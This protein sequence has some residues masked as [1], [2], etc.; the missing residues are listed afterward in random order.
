MLSEVRAA[1][2]LTDKIGRQITYLRMSVTEDCNFRCGYCEGSSPYS[3]ERKSILSDY[4]VIC[5]VRAA[6]K[7]GIKKVRFT[8]GEPLLRGNL[9]GIIKEIS[10]RSPELCIGIT[11]NGFLLDSRLQ[12]LIDAGLNRLNISLDSLDRITFKSLTGID[13]LE[14]VL[15]AIES[16]LA[17]G[18]FDSIKINTVVLR[19]IND[20]EIRSLAE[21]ALPRDIDIRFIEYMPLAGP[22]HVN[23]LYVP[24]SEMREKIGFE[25]VEESRADNSGPARL[26][27]CG[28]YPGRIGFISAVSRCFCGECNRLRITSRGDV[29]GCLFG[30]GDRGLRR[31]LSDGGGEQQIAEYLLT[32][33]EHPGFRRTPGISSIGTRHDRMR[34]IGG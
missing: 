31:L 33:L 5:I 30:E 7:A 22:T 23:D 12:G 6:V 14:R 27:K 10:F 17:S 16:A 1:A 34:S 18:R 29:Y 13:G 11:T 32:L 28:N 20:H 4:E 19:G 25:L 21:W 8:G 2:R 15:S 26:F 3:I 24:E 9:S